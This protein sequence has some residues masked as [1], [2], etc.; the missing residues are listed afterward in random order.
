MAGLNNDLVVLEA[1]YWGI[2]GLPD[3]FKNYAK[4]T[5]TPLQLIAHESLP[6]YGTQFHPEAWDADHPDGCKFLENFFKLAC[7]VE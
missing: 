5:I 6:L 1:H 3:G 2:K 7:V 4:T